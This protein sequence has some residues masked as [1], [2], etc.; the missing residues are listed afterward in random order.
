MYVH[1]IVY[2]HK[3]K[4]NNRLGKKIKLKENGNGATY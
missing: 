3:R 2:K 1:N 4:Y